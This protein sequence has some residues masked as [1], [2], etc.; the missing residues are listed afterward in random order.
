MKSKEIEDYLNKL[1]F[2]KRTFGGLDEADVWRK[3]K[4]LDELY[5]K[6]VDRIII[7][8]EK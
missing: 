1:K 6:E 2:K 7:E 4:K 8:Q 3:I 5:Q